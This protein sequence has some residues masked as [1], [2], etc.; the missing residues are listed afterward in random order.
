MPA[1]E[2]KL[3]ASLTELKRR[4]VFRTGVGYV[5]AAFAVLQAL[6]SVSGAIDLTPVEKPWRQPHQ[7]VPPAGQAFADRENVRPGMIVR[8]GPVVAAFDE[9]GFEWGGDW[10]HASDDDDCEQR[11]WHGNRHL[12]PGKR[13]IAAVDRS[14]DLD[15]RGRPDQS[16]HG[17]GDRCA[18]LPDRSIV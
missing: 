10:R 5:I 18:V 16:A 2:S 11:Q 8:P 14:G 1:P 6:S 3:L 9:L 13:H 4:K 7:L 12:E 17:F 15:Q